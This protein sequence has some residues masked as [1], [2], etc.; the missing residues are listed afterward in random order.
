[1]R[2]AITLLFHHESLR[3]LAEDFGSEVRSYGLTVELESGLHSI[4]MAAIPWEYVPTIASVCMILSTPF[5][6]EFQGEAGRDAYKAVKKFLQRA[7]AGG[8][9][10]PVPYHSMKR[11]S[12]MPVPSRIAIV[13]NPNAEK[14][15]FLWIDDDCSVDEAVEAAR[16]FFVESERVAPEQGSG[17]MLKIAYSF[18]RESRS[19]TVIRQEVLS[20]P[21][22]CR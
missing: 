15:L 16:L 18:D 14:R 20:L 13:A 1:M 2:P 7:I 4:R 5:F 17:E 22:P 9:R 19:L 21:P 11:S 6:K 10:A 3:P 12:S 8:V